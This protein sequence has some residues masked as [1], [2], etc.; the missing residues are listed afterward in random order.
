MSES[1]ISSFRFSELRQLFWSIPPLSLDLY[2]EFPMIVTKAQKHPKKA[3][4]VHC[5]PSAETET[6]SSSIRAS[7]DDIRMCAYY[8]Y[9]KRGSAHGCDT[10]DWAQAE[11]LI[12]QR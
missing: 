3:R 2:G 9:Q 10:Q 5:Q 11:R 12:A 6:T 4:V 7:Q 1:F 8:I